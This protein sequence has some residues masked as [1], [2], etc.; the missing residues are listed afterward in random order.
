MTNRQDSD[1]IVSE[2]WNANSGEWTRQIRQSQDVY[3]EKFLEPEFM[4]FVGSVDGVEV[5]DAGCG[6][7]TSSRVL[8][9]AKARVTA[10]DLSSEMIANAVAA[11]TTAPLGISYQQASVVDLPFPS[12]HFDLVTTWMALSDMSCCADAMKEFSRVLRPGGRIFFCIRHP[13]Y[14]TSRMAVIRRSNTEEPFLLVSDYFRETPWLE[15]WSFAG[16]NQ[17]SEGQLSFSN[18]RFPYTLSDIINGLVQ[19]G[20]LLKELREPRPSENLCKQ[21]P[22]LRFWRKH[23]ALYLFVSAVKGEAGD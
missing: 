15:K 13:C 12:E 4:N 23:A 7:G 11:E 3:R 17:E 19:A 20:F 10:I 16:G 8:A 5:L 21:L 14:F 1:R 18:M 9:K 6:E 2:L 22:R